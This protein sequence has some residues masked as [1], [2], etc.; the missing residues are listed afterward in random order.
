MKIESKYME[1]A[2]QLK[3]NNKI[4]GTNE[5]LKI[6]NSQAEIADTYRRNGKNSKH[7]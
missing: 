2:K 6:V 3:L 4:T 5:S 7:L 1:G